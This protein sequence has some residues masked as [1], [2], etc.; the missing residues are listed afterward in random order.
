MQ[1]MSMEINRVF[2]PGDLEIRGE[3]IQSLRSDCVLERAR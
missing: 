1:E 2:I 3:K